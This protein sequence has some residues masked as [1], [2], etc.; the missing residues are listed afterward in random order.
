MSETGPFAVLG[1]LI[2]TLP[3]MVASEKQPFLTVP[4]SSQ[5]TH[6]GLS[7]IVVLSFIWLLFHLCLS[8]W[9]LILDFWSPTLT[10]WFPFPSQSCLISLPIPGSWIA[11]RSG[12]WM[13]FFVFIAQGPM[14]ITNC[15]SHVANSL[16]LR[17]LLSWQT[18]ICPNS[19]NLALCCHSL[20][21]SSGYQ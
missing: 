13:L 17:G 19:L 8:P 1:L 3:G 15:G 12:F 16:I 21:P 6:F 7:T 10:V 18:E 4:L 9:D 20:L 14:L 2:W 5:L 11:F